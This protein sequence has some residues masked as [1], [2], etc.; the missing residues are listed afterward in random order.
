MTNSEKFILKEQGAKGAVISVL[1]I[2][3]GRSYDFANSALNIAKKIFEL[4]INI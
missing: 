2:F 4:R 3:D 1:K